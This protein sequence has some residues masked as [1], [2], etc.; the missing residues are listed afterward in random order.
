MSVRTV[1]NGETVNYNSRSTGLI[2]TAKNGNGK[3]NGLCQVCHTK[4][5]YFKNYSA[6]DMNHNSG[7]DCL[8]CH[9]HKGRQFAF[10]PNGGCGACHGYPPVR[11]NVTAIRLPGTIGTQGN[12]SSAKFQDY[13]GGGGAH[14]VAGHIPKSAEAK[15]SW[16]NCTSCHFD[17]GQHINGGT[18]VKKSFV[19]VTVDPQFKFNNFTAIKYNAQTC[20]NVSCH[21]KKSPNWTNGL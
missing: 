5:K 20:S 3:Y 2:V 7:K 8:D 1:I 14:A 15:Q 19:N 9:T 21:F 12:Y 4:V 10:E 17:Q 16:T 18:P 13:S 6:P 11:A